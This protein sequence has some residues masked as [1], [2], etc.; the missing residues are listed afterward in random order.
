MSDT[1]EIA[2]ASDEKYFC[3]LLVTAASIAKFAN[4]NAVLSF[5]ILD[6]GIQDKDYAYLISCVTS[7]NPKSTFTRHKLNLENPNLSKV[8]AYLGNKMT[9]ARL[10]LPAML[11][12]C[13]FVIYSD[14]DI[15]WLADIERVWK[16]R[17]PTCSYISSQDSCKG[18]LEMEKRWFNEHGLAFCVDNYFCAG[19]SLINLQY[20]QEH[21]ISKRVFDFLQKHKTTNCADQTGLNAV[22]GSK[23]QLLQRNWQ[24]F[25]RNGIMESDI[26]SQVLIHYAGET[27]WKAS[28][29]TH[30]LTDTQLLW[31]RFDAHVRGISLWQSLRMHYSSWKIVL[32]R[33][34]FGAISCGLGN[35]LFRYYMHRTGRGCFNERLSAKTIKTFSQRLD[36]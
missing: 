28:K 22:L 27:P 20:F 12:D 30:L 19:F 2:L 33:T 10:L 26:E 36:A 1:V 11:H 4:P 13:D 14:I 35:R 23:V 32:W 7:I 18:T 24:L 25:P 31:F 9:Y 16:L 6:G 29:Q 21:D 5:N 8:P 17:S 3:G 15:L 34:I